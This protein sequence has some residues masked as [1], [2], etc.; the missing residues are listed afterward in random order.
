MELWV[1]SQD[2][3]ALSKYDL[4]IVEETPTGKYMFIADHYKIFGTYMTKQRAL[5]VLDEIEERICL[6]NTMSLIHDNNSLISF[7]NAIGE[8]KVKGLAYPY[9]MPKE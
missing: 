1:R 5:E 3:M 8:D 4:L 7:K 2:K 9:Q 6:L